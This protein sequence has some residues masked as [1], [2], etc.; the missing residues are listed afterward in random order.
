MF[1]L[2]TYNTTVVSRTLQSRFRPGTFV[3]TS[4]NCDMKPPAINNPRDVVHI[5]ILSDQK[6]TF[7]FNYDSDESWEHDKNTTMEGMLFFLRYKNCRTK[8]DYFIM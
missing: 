6:I 5:N 8:F 3:L 7:N 1:G 2:D 4:S